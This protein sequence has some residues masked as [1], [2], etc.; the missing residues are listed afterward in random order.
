M[1]ARLVERARIVLGCLEGKPVS[2]VA[3]SLIGD[4]SSR[5][6]QEPERFRVRNPKPSR[7]IRRMKVATAHFAEEAI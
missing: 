5:Q 3:D 7:V 1:E 6:T 4:D 2:A